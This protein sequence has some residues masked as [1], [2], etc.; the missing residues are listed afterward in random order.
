[1]KCFKKNEEEI[2]KSQK[3]LYNS[4]DYKTLVQT[5][6]ETLLMRPEIVDKMNELLKL[7]GD[8]SIYR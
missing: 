7:S 1:M 3:T 5:N 8:I 6:E 4:E 2:K